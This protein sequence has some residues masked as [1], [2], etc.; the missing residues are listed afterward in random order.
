ME[1]NVTV[2]KKVRMHFIRFLLRKVAGHDRYG[3]DSKD[4]GACRKRGKRMHI[5]IILRKLTGVDRKDMGRCHRGEK[6]W[7]CTS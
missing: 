7:G 2:E 1:A 3:W 4:T 5:R 6:G